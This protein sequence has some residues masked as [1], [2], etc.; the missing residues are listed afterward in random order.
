MPFADAM[1]SSAFRTRPTGYP[2]SI[3]AV[4]STAIESSTTGT[5]TVAAVAVGERGDGSAAGRRRRSD[6]TNSPATISTPRAMNKV[7][8]EIVDVAMAGGTAGTG[9]ALE[10]G[11]GE[12]EGE[13]EGVDVAEGVGLV[14]SVGEGSGVAETVGVGTMASVWVGLG[15]A[16]GV[17]LAVSSAGC[18]GA[19][20]TALTTDSVAKAADPAG[21]ASIRPATSAATPANARRLSRALAPRIAVAFS[22]GGAS[23]QR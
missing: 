18:S 6:Q 9:V 20:V 11:V 8:G 5:G 15:V 2:L 12:A 13:G 14:V 3:I 16:V 1:S 4:P 21:S 19:G 22:L 10:V 17:G 23:E 7:K